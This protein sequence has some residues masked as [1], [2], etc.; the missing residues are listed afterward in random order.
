MLHSFAQLDVW[1]YIPGEFSKFLLINSVVHS[2]SHFMQNPV[3]VM[4]FVFHAIDLLVG[5]LLCEWAMR[6]PFCVVSLGLKSG[7]C[8]PRRTG[9]RRGLRRRCGRLYEGGGPNIVDQGIRVGRRFTL[10]AESVGES[11]T[12]TEQYP[13]THHPAPR[14][15]P[16]PVVR[17]VHWG[18][19][20]QDIGERT[21]CYYPTHMQTSLRPGHL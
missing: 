13:D 14:R 4:C 11:E 2:W 9:R 5:Q 21:R 10:L 18:S 17:D 15:H 1:D 8:L 19:G 6:T 7:A 3:T 16:V 20:R 12:T